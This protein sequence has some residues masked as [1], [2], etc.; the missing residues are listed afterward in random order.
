MF[1]IKFAIFASV[2]GVYKNYWV[3]GDFYEE[4]GKYANTELQVQKMAQ[5][6]EHGNLMAYKIRTRLDNGSWSNWKIFTLTT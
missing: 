6:D 3:G 4:S 1:P 5:L 2:L